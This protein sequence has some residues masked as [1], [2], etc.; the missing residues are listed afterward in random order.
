M[1]LVWTSMELVNQASTNKLSLTLKLKTHHT[2]ALLY[3]KS[4]RSMVHDD[5][6]GKAVS[7]RLGGNQVLPVAVQSCP[8]LAGELCVLV[9]CHHHCTD[10][11]QQACSIPEVIST[12]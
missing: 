9:R 7:A 10:V 12:V 2:K 8:S 11:G 3:L 1:D 4:G 6:L 5:E